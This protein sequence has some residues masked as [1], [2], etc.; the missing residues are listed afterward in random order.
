MTRAELLE[1]IDAGENSGVE[2]KRD[3]LRPEQ[4]AREVAALANFQ[5]GRVLLGVEDDGSITG[6][7]RPDLEQWVMDA[8]FGR[9]VHPMILPFYEEVPV[10]AARRV[11]VVTVTPGAVKPYVVRQR[12][13]EDIYVRVGSTSRLATREQQ[14]RLFATGGL[15][16]TELLPVSGSSLAD[17]SR[18]RLADYLT[19]V[20]ADRRPPSGDAQW[21]ERLCALGFMVERDAGPPACTIAGLLLFGYRPRRLLRHAGVRWMCFEG[22]GKADAA[23]DDQ[24]IEGPLTGL[25]RELSG[26]RELVEKGLIERLADAMRPFVSEEPIAVDESMRRERRWYYPLDALREGIVNALTHRDWTRYEQVEVVRYADRVEILSPGALRN[27]MTVAKMIAGQRVPRNLLISEVLRDY[28]YADARG[29]GVRN[30]IIPLMRARNGVDPEFEAT[31]DY[32]RLTLRRRAAS[33]A[34]VGAAD[35]TRV[36]CGDGA[37]QE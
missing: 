35:D 15:L 33:P 20:T 2:F 19:A 22:G 18:E 27:G 36:G 29:M 13:R 12:G 28:D 8:V 31:E 26:G 3:D 23:L 1:L 14:A 9:L 17:L 7:R 32:L 30:R 5:G 21:H 24:V 6:V 37:G 16:H 10:D 4:L 34:G 25:W 11:A